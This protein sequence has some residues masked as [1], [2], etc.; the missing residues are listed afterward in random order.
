[1][2]VAGWY[3]GFDRSERCGADSLSAQGDDERGIAVSWIAL[4]DMTFNFVS[5]EQHEPTYVVGRHTAD[6]AALGS[7]AATDCARALTVGGWTVR[8]NNDSHRFPE[9]DLCARPV[10]S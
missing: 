10:C 3:P 6:E 9:N 5:P 7:A 1:V 2:V 8:A 4:L